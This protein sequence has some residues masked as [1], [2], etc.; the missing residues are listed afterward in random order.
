MKAF[1]IFRFIDEIGNVAAAAQILKRN[2]R[3]SP[4]LAIQH[5]YHLLDGSSTNFVDVDAFGC[6]INYSFYTLPA[7]FICKYRVYL[8]KIL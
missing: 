1:V 4:P 6:V 2:S 8:L 3:E 7:V 5:T